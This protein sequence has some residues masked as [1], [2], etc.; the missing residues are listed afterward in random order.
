MWPRV[1]LLRPGFAFNTFSNDAYLEGLADCVE[2]GLT[3]AVGVSNFS[4]RRVKTAAAAFTRRGTSLSSNQVGGPGGGG[5]GV[6]CLGRSLCSSFKCM[7]VCSTSVR[8]MRVRVL[9]CV[10]LSACMR[11]HAGQGL[12]HACLCT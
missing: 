4:A 1:L 2:Q 6:H 3:Q 8:C 5:G 7:C 10:R 12:V 11:I 9:V